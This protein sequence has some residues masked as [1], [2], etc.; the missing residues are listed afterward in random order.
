MAVVIVPTSQT[1]PAYRRQVQLDGVTYRFRFRWNTRLGS[2]FF[3][4]E[5]EDGTVIVYARRV[6]IDWFFLTQS[7]DQPVPPGLLVAFDTTLRDDPPRIDDFGTRVLLGYLDE[8]ERE[9]L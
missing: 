7:R 2:W 3:D 1:L 4:L 5:A 8:S 6:V 9:A